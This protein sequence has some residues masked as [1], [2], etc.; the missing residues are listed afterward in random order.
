MSQPN[1]D[2]RLL[3]PPPLYPPRGHRGPLFRVPRLPGPRHWRGG[4]G[5]PHRAFPHPPHP[6]P[7]GMRGNFLHPRHF[8]TPK[9]F[10][11]KHKEKLRNMRR[12]M[13]RPVP[14]PRDKSSEVSVQQQTRP[15][16]LKDAERALTFETEY[17]E[18]KGKTQI[19][20]EFPDTEVDR[21]NVRCLHPN[22]NNVYF[23]SPPMPRYC[24]VQLRP[25]ADV[26]K[27]LSDLNSKPLPEFNGKCL[28]ATL[29]EVKKEELKPGDIDPYTLYIGNIPP[30]VNLTFFKEFFPNA[31]RKDI[32]HAQKLKNTRY[33]FVR[34]SCLKDAIDG[35]KRM[36]NK[37]F[38][39]RSVIVRFKRFRESKN[40][41]TEVP[42][43]SG[44]QGGDELDEEEFH[45]V[46]ETRSQISKSSSGSSED[47]PEETEEYNP[48][49]YDMD[50]INPPP[51]PPSLALLRFLR[52]NDEDEDSYRDFDPKR[53]MTVL[54]DDVISVRTTDSLLD[55]DTPYK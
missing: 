17:N 45:Y 15:W 4:R 34:F 40:A 52:S 18:S 41:S 38:D 22:I 29:A 3:M 7:P 30:H 10:H 44:G 2:P 31:T 46:P 9:V 49:E 55:L 6:P 14:A 39:S 23:K 37:E 13:K 42:S 27:V 16:N 28:R 33:A 36:I 48:E 24:Y 50:E 20:I 32:G 54:P 8:H 43:H 11:Q 21:D 51:R 26:N 47:C 19:K 1:F 5:H 35:F 12:E 25:D 53:N